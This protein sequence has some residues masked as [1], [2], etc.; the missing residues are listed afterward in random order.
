MAT[1]DLISYF[2]GE[3]C[4]SNGI[5]K[6]VEDTF[7]ATAGAELFYRLIALLMP[8]QHCQNRK[9][10]LFIKLN[11]THSKIMMKY[12][13]TFHFWPKPK[14]TPKA[15]LDLWPKLNITTNMNWAFNSKLKRKLLG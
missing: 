6:F 12:M 1:N 14:I 7:F 3:T 5:P 11:N 8:K 15:V 13:L 4:L 10:R 2:S 9:R